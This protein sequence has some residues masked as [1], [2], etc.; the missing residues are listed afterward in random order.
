MEL[1]HF[2]LKENPKSLPRARRTLM[3][4]WMLDKMMSFLFYFLLLWL[5]VNYSESA[6]SALDSTLSLLY[7]MPFFRKQ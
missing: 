2:L 5:L 3:F 7:H 1:E 6:R 4:L